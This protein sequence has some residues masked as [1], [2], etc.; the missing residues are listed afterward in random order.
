MKSAGI[1][2]TVLVLVGYG[3]MCTGQVRGA[4]YGEGVRPDPLTAGP[5]VVVSQNGMV[6]K[7]PLARN[8]TIP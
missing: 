6:T 2:L 4:G 1:L 3:V 5:Y 8:P 7:V